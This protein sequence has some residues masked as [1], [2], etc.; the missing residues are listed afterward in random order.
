ML[1]TNFDNPI[2]EI[3]SVR[4]ER[5]KTDP[6]LTPKTPT[7]F[8]DMENVYEHQLIDVRNKGVAEEGGEK[9]GRSEA[10]RPE[11]APL[12]RASTSDTYMF[13]TQPRLIPTSAT[14]SNVLTPLLSRSLVAGSVAEVELTNIGVSPN[15]NFVIAGDK[16]GHLYIRNMKDK[17][18]GKAEK[19]VLGLE[20][21]Q[22][23]FGR[24]LVFEGEIEDPFEPKHR[25]TVS[26]RGAKVYLALSDGRIAYLDLQPEEGEPKPQIFQAHGER[27]ECLALCRDGKDKDGK[28]LTSFLISAKGRE[29]K[30]WNTQDL[31]SEEKLVGKIEVE[32]EGAVT[33]TISSVAWHPNRKWFCLGGG[34][35]YNKNFLKVYE[36]DHEKNEHKELD[37]PKLVNGVEFQMAHKKQVNCLTFARNGKKLFSGSRD[38]HIKIWKT[39]SPDGPVRW[40][41]V[42]TLVGHTHFVSCISESH[43]G[44]MLVSG[45]DDGTIR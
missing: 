32:E 19:M 31:S 40:K 33:M 42:T 20:P 45:G 34:D 36:W 28:D 24:G 18:D 12:R 1:G 29:A 3:S 13:R 38:K 39:S 16:N 21:P 30:I 35:P 43:C 25:V 8:W 11:K 26:E 9:W 2:M 22:L 15:R 6:L 17:K 4:E 41:L 14:V 7:A 27:V 5:S 23:G 10:A 44:R 37:T